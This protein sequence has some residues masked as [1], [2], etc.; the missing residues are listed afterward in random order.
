MGGRY[1]AGLIEGEARRRKINP[2][3]A[4][5]L[6][7]LADPKTGFTRS[8][9]DGVVALCTTY[10]YPIALSVIFRC[11]P[12]PKGERKRLLQEA[13]QGRWNRR[14]LALELRERYPSRRQGDRKPKVVGEFNEA[15]LQL[16]DSAF[17]LARWCEAFVESRRKTAGR[18]GA[19]QALRVIQQ[20]LQQIQLAAEKQAV[21][22]AP[23]RRP[24]K[25]TK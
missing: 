9:L 23:Q 20:A 12:V 15:V 22:Q 3:T 17:Q 16:Q 13:A 1:G 6:R 8:E 11:L 19:Q 24:R 7:Q 21:Q 4:R 5:K 10:E 25:K 2:D 14:R 18:R